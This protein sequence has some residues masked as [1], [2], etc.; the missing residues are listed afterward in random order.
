MCPQCSDLKRQKEKDASIPKIMCMS[1]QSQ[2][3]GKLKSYQAGPYGVMTECLIL[4]SDKLN[5]I[6]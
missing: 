6:Q 4:Y 1:R 2:C 3:G 5:C